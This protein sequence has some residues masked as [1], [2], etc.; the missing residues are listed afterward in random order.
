MVSVIDLD[1]VLVAEQIEKKCAEYE[2]MRVRKVA[3]A[4]AWALEYEVCVA[5]GTV[6]R[7]FIR[8]PTSVEHENAFYKKCI[9]QEREVYSRARIVELP[10]L[11][12]KKFV[13]VYG[14]SATDTEGTGPFESVEKASNWFFHGGR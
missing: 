5:N 4:E 8:R 10:S 7:K 1:P 11:A 6:G 9:D 12:G 13:L 14:E 2:A 3:E